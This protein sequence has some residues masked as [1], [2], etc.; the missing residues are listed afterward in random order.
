MSKEE[1]QRVDDDLNLHREDC[2]GLLAQ[3]EAERIAQVLRELY[4]DPA[5]WWKKQKD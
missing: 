1:A 4:E 3:V 2:L 5:D